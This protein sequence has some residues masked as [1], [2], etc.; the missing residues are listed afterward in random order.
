[1]PKLHPRY[2]IVKKAE[3]EL[4]KAVMDIAQKHELTTAEQLKVVA[5]ALGDAVG[6][7]AKYA[8]RQE[9]HGDSDTPGDWD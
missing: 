5:A 6:S 9:R 4:S 1:M 7:I 3:V 8:I 2:W